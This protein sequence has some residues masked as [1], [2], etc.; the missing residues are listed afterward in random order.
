MNI[1]DVKIRLNIDEPWDVSRIID[2]KV[3][4]IYRSDNGEIYLS[5]EDSLT[6][7]VF[8]VSSRYVGVDLMKVFSG[9]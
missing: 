5:I 6:G 3:T 7:E 4:I 2:G 8:V 9:A 1:K